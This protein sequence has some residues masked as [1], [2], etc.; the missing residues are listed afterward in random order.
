DAAAPAPVVPASA[1]V[2]TAVL[3]VGVLGQVAVGLAGVLP[4]P[5][6]VLTATLLVVVA[7]RG[8]F[9]AGRLRP[10]LLSLVG[11]G[12]GLCGLVAL[13]SAGSQEGVAP[14]LVGLRDV[15]G[16]VLVALQL[17]HAL[18][19]RTR[20]D[21]QV[22]M[23]VGGGLLV[24]SGSYAPDL[25]VGLPLLAGGTGA[26]AATVLLVD[27]R[28]ADGADVVVAGGSG[29]GLAVPVTTALAVVLALVAFLLIPV[30]KKAG[31]RTT[32]SAAGASATPR[33][34]RAAALSGDA[35]DTSARGRLGETALAEVPSDSPVLWRSRTF[36]TWDGRSWTRPQERPRQ[37]GGPP[38][39]LGATTGG[40]LRTDLVQ[41]PTTDGTIWSP[42]ADVRRV[43]V[44]GALAIDRDG[45]LHTGRR[46]GSYTITTAVP[47]TTAALLRAT[48]PV[49]GQDLLQLPAELP[50][51]VRD[52]ARQITAE[53]PTAYDKVRAVEQWLA[54]HAAYQLDSPVPAAGED[55]V[56][57]FLFVDRV[58][59]CEQFAAAETVLLRSVGVPARLVTGLAYGTDL[60]GGRRGYQQKD[61]HAWVE[62]P[63]AGVGWVSSDPT[64][65]AAKA[66]AG[67]LTPRQRLDGW[68]RDALASTQPFPGG[69][70][71]LAAVLLVTLVAAALVHRR[72]RDRLPL[73]VTGA[74]TGP[75]D[76]PYDTRSR[77]ALAAFLRL[78]RRIGP[79]GRRPHESLADM[80][81]RLGPDPAVAA[82]FEVVQ[83]EC[84]APDPPPADEAVRALD[85]YLPA[86]AAQP[87]GRGGPAATVSRCASSS[88]A[89]RSTTSA[90]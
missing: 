49:G 88:P 10:A 15:L 83:Q 25:V 52:L 84:Y 35:L 4:L 72:R 37:V 46:A 43:E 77:P 87:G 22:A 56:D 18:S 40:P 55:A 82:A 2:R 5:L 9:C 32:A 31:I 45:S 63:Y 39:V 61:L 6:A 3:A 28:R 62:V 8:A 80:R 79:Q 69:R 65:G 16:P 66:A 29:R 64:A 60:G 81:R 19:W 75:P 23:L 74:R 21:L 76:I 24:L 41:L 33:S 67:G 44:A 12:A 53:A 17:L 68:L 58:G 36:S 47:A 90:D 13:Q 26:V 50:G 20:R 27:L 42:G 11:I 7:R 57:R 38:Y 30:P 73:P 54:A 85:D 89:A 71:G 59:F 34:D 86:G 51:R 48:R 14:S 70:R 78:D 1:G